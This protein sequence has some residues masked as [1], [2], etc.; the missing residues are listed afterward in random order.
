MKVFRFWIS[1][2]LLNVTVFA[3]IS[4][5]FSAALPCTSLVQL[6]VGWNATV[7]GENCCVP[8]NGGETYAVGDP[9]EESLAT[10]RAAANAKCG[11]RRTSELDA[12]GILRCTDVFGTCGAP[13]NVTCQ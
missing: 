10:A 12:N 7:E 6:C 2:I 11:I 9:A 4:F 3:G 5:G 8:V 13:A 1:V